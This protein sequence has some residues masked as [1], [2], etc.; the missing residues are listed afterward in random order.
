MVAGPKDVTLEALLGVTVQR[1]MRPSWPMRP[2]T[3]FFLTDGAFGV[4]AARG[5]MRLPVL[6]G[7]GTCMFL[8]WNLGTAL[9]VLAGELVPDVR[10]LGVDF[11]ATLAF[12]AVLI[13]LLKRRGGRM[14]RAIPLSL[15]E[16]VRARAEPRWIV[17][18]VAFLTTVFLAHWV[19]L[20]AAVLGAGLAGCGVGA[21]LDRSTA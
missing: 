18:L 11:V 9:G 19:P 13:P 12:L 3:A 8:G 7:T 15:W 6:L 1:L 21:L 5:P 4:A 2:L 14:P 20:G 10:R 16:T 17:A